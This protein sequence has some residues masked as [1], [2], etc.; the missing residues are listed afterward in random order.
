M[1]VGYAV[2]LCGFAFYIC[3]LRDGGRRIEDPIVHSECIRLNKFI[4]LFIPVLFIWMGIAT[5][6]AFQSFLVLRGET[7]LSFLKSFGSRSRTDVTQGT[8][9]K[10]VLNL[11]LVHYVFPILLEIYPLVSKEK[12]L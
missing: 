6:I 11:R 2:A 7:T 12:Q 4:V 1:G 5:L 9:V 3:V 8:G 10:S